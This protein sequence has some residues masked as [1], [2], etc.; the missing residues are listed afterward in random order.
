MAYAGLATFGYSA[1][2]HLDGSIA[3][4]TRGGFSSQNTV[5]SSLA[6]FGYG[7]SGAIKNVVRFGFQITAG[8]AVP[9]GKQIVTV[10]GLPWSVTAYSILTGAS[11]TVINGDVIM[12]DLRS[13]PGN[14]PITMNSDGTF[15]IAVNG[16]TARQS[17]VSDV[18]NSSFTVNQGLFTT[19]VN[20]NSPVQPNSAD[21]LNFVVGG[22]IGN[23]DLNQY[24]LDI[25]GDTLTYSV[26]PATLPAG[27]T[28][29]GSS[30]NGIVTQ[31]GGFTPSV[32]ATDITGDSTNLFPVSMSITV[33]ADGPL[34]DILDPDHNGT[35][36]M[37]IRRHDTEGIIS[38]YVT[39]ID[40]YPG[41]GRWV[42]VLAYI[43]DQS[44]ADAILSALKI[45]DQPNFIPVWPV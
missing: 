28:L 29:V 37:L 15:K 33:A 41:R 7:T 36:V 44:K 19:W 27:V 4:V 39:S 11:P 9:A 34:Q 10:S 2:G 17:F 22:N 5:T 6:T 1:A 26:D 3:L 20:N 14:Y 25:E 8:I 16:D 13:T 42:N 40:I 18:Y 32:T 12:T 21:D 30:L 38:Y 24:I 31:A 45:P 35:G 43:D 23:I